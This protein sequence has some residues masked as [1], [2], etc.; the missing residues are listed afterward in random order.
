MKPGVYTRPARPMRITVKLRP[1][2]ANVEIARV[3]EIIAV[4][5]ATECHVTPPDV[6]ARMVRYLG[7]VG[8]YLTLE[9]SA[10][11]GNLSRALIESGHSRY[12]LVQV[13]RHIKLAAQLHRFGTVIN[14]CFLE[15]SVEV[16]GKV[17]FPRVIMNPPFREVRKHIAAAR[18]LMGPHG[19]GE[20]P[21]L[22]ALVPITFQTDGMETL[23]HLPDDTFDTAKVRTKIIRIRSDPH[24]TES[25]RKR[26]SFEPSQIAP[27]AISTEDL[28]GPGSDQI[29][30]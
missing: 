20:A 26:W 6:A 9:P 18:D 5:S 29:A 3:P 24:P 22:V 2:F 16:R 27:S 1:G 19:H 4:D 23:E 8:D 7:E 11:T 10:G 12:E 21:T 14:R 28:T 13:E 30:A 25:G 17:E 15:Y